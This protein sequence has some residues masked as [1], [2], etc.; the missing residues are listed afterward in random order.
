MIVPAKKREKKRKMM[1]TLCKATAALSADAQAA[2][3]VIGLLWHCI[4]FHCLG[5]LWVGLGTVHLPTFPSY[6]SHCRPQ[7]WRQEALGYSEGRAVWGHE[8]V[9]GGERG[10]MYCCYGVVRVKAELEGLLGI[11]V[12]LY[13]QNYRFKLTMTQF[14]WIVMHELNFTLF[15]IPCCSIYL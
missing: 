11:Y 13:L 10:H 7:G 5:W 1:D 12:H 9:L 14:C 6:A 2:G 8:A 15:F 4:K 3:A